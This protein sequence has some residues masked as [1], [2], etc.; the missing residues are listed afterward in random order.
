MEI[1][2]HHLV[3]RPPIVI[4]SRMKPGYPAELKV[5]EDVSDL[6]DRRWNEYF[7][8]GTKWSR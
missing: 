8:Q 7:P 3:Y 1:R 4:D 2:R 5:R 6:V